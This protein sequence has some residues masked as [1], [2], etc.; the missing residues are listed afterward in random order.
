MARITVAGVVA[1]LGFDVDDTGAKR[2]EGFIKKA[3][4]DARRDVKAHLGA[5]VD[6]RTFDLYQRRLKEAEATAQRRERFKAELGADFDEKSFRAA[7]REFR[8][9]DAAMKAAEHSGSGFGARI[10]FLSGSLEKIAVV[11]AALAPLVISL[12]GAFVALTASLAAAAAGAAAVGVGLASIL[13]PLGVLATAVSQRV[14]VISEAWDALTRKEED[15]GKAATSSADAQKAA[16]DRVASAQQTLTDAQRN[17]R[18]AREDLADALFRQRRELADLRLEAERS[19][20][21]EKRAQLTLEQSVLRLQELQDDPTA[22]RIDIR[23]AKLAVEEAQMSLRT[24]RT[25]RKRAHEDA[26]RGVQT[27]RDAERQLAAARRQTARAQEDVA[28]AQEQAAEAV[29]KTS[30]AADDAEQKLAKLTDAER[31]VLET[32][33]KFSDAFT[34]AFRPATDAIFT[35]VARA[36]ER[37]Q[38]LLGRYKSRFEELGETIGS[39]FVRASK[40][41]VGP[42]WT[43]AID[44]FITLANRV[45]EPLSSALGSLAEVFRNIAEAARPFVIDFAEGLARTFGEWA[46]GTDNVRAVR[47]VIEELVEHTEAWFELFKSVGRVMLAIFGGGEE[48]GKGFVEWL[49]DALNKWAAFL[50]TEEGQAAMRDFFEDAIRLLRDIL[51]ILKPVVDTFIFLTDTMVALVD[52]TRESFDQLATDIRNLANAFADAGNFIADVV[53]EIGQAATDV[54]DFLLE[55]LSRV[56]GG[57]QSLFEFAGKL[58]GVGGKFKG[59]AQ[60]IQEIRDGL[61]GF[62]EGARDG[63][64]EADRFTLEKIRDENRRTAKTFRELKKDANLDDVQLNVKLNAELIKQDLGKNSREGREALAKNFQE[65]QEAVRRQMKRGVIATRDGMKAIRGYLIDELQLY[66]FNLRQARNIA[67]TG[68]PDANEGREGGHNRQRGGRTFRSGGWLGAGRGSIGADN[69][70]IGGNAWAASGEFYAPGPGGTGAVFN[71]HQAPIVEAHL[72]RGGYSLD[73][74][75]RDHRALPIIEYA[76]GGP[77][78][79]DMLFASITRP[80]MYASG[81]RPNMDGAG[82]HLLPA[83]ILAH[84]RYGLDVTSGYRPWDTDSHHGDRNAIDISNGYATPEE[85]AFGRH[86][87]RLWGPKLAE[88]IHTPM[89]FSIDNGV[90]TAPFARADHY[91]HVHLAALGPLGRLA[92]AIKRIIIRGGG[93]VGQ[94]AQRGLDIARGAANRTLRRVESVPFGTSGRDRPGAKQGHIANVW[95]QINPNDGDPR[96]MSAIAMAESSGVE[97]AHG[98]PDG[99]GWYQ[100]EWPIWG[101]ALSKYGNPFVGRDNTRMARDVLQQQGLGA[102][103]V[104]NTG[105]FRRYLGRGGRRLRQFFNGGGRTTGANVESGV[106]DVRDPYNIKVLR[107]KNRDRKEAYEQQIVLVESLGRDYEYY[108]RKYGQSE[109]EFLNEDGSLNQDAINK[110]IGELEHLMQIRQ[111]IVTALVKARRIAR[112]IIATYKDVIERLRKARKSAKKKDRSGY[113][114]QIQQFQG[115]IADWEGTV[116]DLNDD[117]RFARLDVTDISNEI[118]DVRGTKA[119]PRGPTDIEE[120]TVASEKARADALAAENV[121]LT[122]TLRAFTSPGDIGAGYANAYSAGSGGPVVVTPGSGGSVFIQNNQMLQPGDPAVL[123]GVA[124]AAVGG[125]SQQPFRA[126]TRE[127]YNI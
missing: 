39:I 100:I 70:P 96:L 101:K 112:R 121:A 102:W 5:E 106:G 75:P 85:L 43:R 123:R 104:Y 61:E 69:I 16:A 27:V 65:A 59:I 71:R 10:G 6:E 117:I 119:E 108:D 46:R 78:A 36:L 57:F 77:T 116:T 35:G 63:K 25:E 66:G 50:E 11:A 3:R 67:R 98:P 127:A 47:D 73:T 12:G 2:F 110:R 81:G 105:A 120:A 118:A 19:I 56:L 14:G 97:T 28:R 17:E 126:S 86:A 84:R 89:G 52:A 18:F 93:A 94:V 99:R 53:Y 91:D 45:V 22:N 80:H 49:T 51:H 44:S 1:R 41:L 31:R 32:F 33:K 37:I 15:A 68:D 20:L 54:F 60:D 87:A 83:A 34:I 88:L 103:V 92:A 58:P 82:R 76:M 90:R 64:R 113:T 125:F 111:A 95:R 30:A 72:A 109:E 13:G 62:G 24:A 26:A 114:S 79:V 9:I 124:A 8:R 21:S 40:S 55:A 7:E 122:A 42:E 48:A 29:A 74:L 4:A 107:R 115:F 23:E 38:P